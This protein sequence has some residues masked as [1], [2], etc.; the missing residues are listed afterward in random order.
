MKAWL[1]NEP[2]SIDNLVWKETE[3]VSAG[4]GELVVRVISAALNPVDYKMIESGSRNWNYPH[5][6]GVDLAGEVIEVGP[7]AT[8]F[9]V[10]DQVA[11]HTDLNKRG[12]FAEKAVIRAETAAKIPEGVSFDQAAAILCAGMTA[13]QAVYQKLNHAQ[14]E[15]ILIHAGAGG[16]GGFAIQLA[17]ELGL[18]VFTTASFEN[19]AWVKSL[20]VDITIDY[21]TEDVTRRIL[22]ETNQE[23]VDLI[24]N[25]VGSREATEDLKRLSFSG[26]LA[27]VA[28]SPDL[29]NVKPFSLSPSIH[30]VALGAAHSSGSIRARVNL[31]FMAKELMDRI[32]NGTLDPMI[33]EV[34][35]REELPNGLKK[36]KTRHVRGKIIVRMQ[37]E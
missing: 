30:E 33:S 22:E 2:G 3:D 5:V 35:P 24:V 31:S 19:H 6:T 21:K 34:L 14:K 8:D 32:K 20:G 13:Y 4:R 12:S 18:K 25:T 10:G 9:K 28:G 29:S 26:H 37:A 15:T 36:V 7:D 27:Y 1:I 23:G 11:C 16:V 17:K